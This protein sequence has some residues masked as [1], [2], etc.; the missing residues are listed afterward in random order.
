MTMMGLGKTPDKI[1][2]ERFDKYLRFKYVFDRIVQNLKDV[3]IEI[4]SVV[5]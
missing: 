1:P 2:K 5:F 4:R 3:P